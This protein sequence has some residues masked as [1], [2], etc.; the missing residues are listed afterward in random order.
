MLRIGVVALALAILGGDARADSVQDP[1]QPANW[2]GTW[3]VTAT[4]T[5]STCDGT[6]FG[7]V[8]GFQLKIQFKNGKLTAR[9]TS[10]GGQPHNYDFNGFRRSIPVVLLL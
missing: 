9:E 7:D 6:N 3:T 10:S 2:I 5:Y 1:T 4:A 8:A